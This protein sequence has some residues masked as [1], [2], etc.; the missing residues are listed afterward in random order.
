MT[1]KAREQMLHSIGE[2]LVNGRTM[3]KLDF[4]GTVR[5][6]GDYYFNVFRRY[7]NVY[8]IVLED[9]AGDFH[10]HRD[11]TVRQSIQKV[12]C[13]SDEQME[14]L[15]T[16]D[17]IAFKNHSSDIDEI[18][19]MR[20]TE[21][22]HR[23]YGVDMNLGGILQDFHCVPKVKLEDSDMTPPLEIVQPDTPLADRTCIFSPIAT[24]INLSDRFTA[25]ENNTTLAEEGVT[26]LRNGTRIAKPLRR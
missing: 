25:V 20:W 11:Y 21:I 2:M 15:Y 10:F 7:N 5:I 23:W 13:L 8:E 16:I 24:P 3:T 14:G 4:L 9:F 17:G 6:Y 19:G 26:V 22:Q 18:T 12:L 1:T